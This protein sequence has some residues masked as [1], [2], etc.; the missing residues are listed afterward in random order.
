MRDVTWRDMCPTNSFNACDVEEVASDRGGKTSLKSRLCI[1]RTCV[2]FILTRN[3][4]KMMDMLWAS[5]N[6]FHVEQLWTC[7]ES[8][9][10]GSSGEA[11]T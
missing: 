11:S 4:Y 1:Q 10:V 6:I 2:H 8:E 3:S 9:K 5:P 7:I